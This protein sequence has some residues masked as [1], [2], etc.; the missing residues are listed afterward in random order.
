MRKFLFLFL[1]SSFSFA[2]TKIITG[3]VS[4]TL[5]NPLE[6]ANIIALP[7]SEKGSFLAY[8]IDQKHSLVLNKS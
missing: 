2:Q 1:L 3:V 7:K 6:S 5:T 4:D 8:Y